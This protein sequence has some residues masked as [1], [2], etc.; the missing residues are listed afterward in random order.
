VTCQLALAV[1]LSQLRSLSYG[2]LVLSLH[3][4]LGLLILLLVAARMVLAWARGDSVA[5]FGLIPLPAPLELSDETRERLMTVHGA[6]AIL[7]FSLCLIH[8][9]A[10]LFNRVVRHVSVIDRMLPPISS[11]K[12]VNRVG[13]G[14]QLSMAF[15]L[16]IGTALLVAVNA[17]ATYRDVNR[18][19]AA[20]QAEGV[21]V[22]DQLC[23]AQVAWKDFYVQLAGGPP[24]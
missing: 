8:V 17:I 19:N 16:L 24:R 12:L 18:A 5:V 14:A 20:F 9:G 10:V 6:T 13:V 2:Q 1:V 7:L 3:R 4:Q 22:A 21:A 15:T 23:T 11:H